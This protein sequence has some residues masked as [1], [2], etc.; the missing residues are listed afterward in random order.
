MLSVI[1]F[2]ICQQESESTV[3]EWKNPTDPSVKR[4]QEVIE[5]YLQNQ[6]DSEQENLINLRA[7]LAIAERQRDN[8]QSGKNQDEQLKL[9]K[10]QQLKALQA[11][12][13]HYNKIISSIEAQVIKE[14]RKDRVKKK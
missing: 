14:K 11:E 1:F 2:L 4:F 6:F 3:G 9:K 5:S 8:I 12:I 10:P 13:D 7:R